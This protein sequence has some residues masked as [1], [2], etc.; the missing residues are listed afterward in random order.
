[1]RQSAPTLLALS[2][3]SRGQCESDEEFEIYGV[4]FRTV[5]HGVHEMNANPMIANLGFDELADMA[6]EDPEGAFRGFTG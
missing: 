5:A 3:R 4:M 6:R 1:M 2:L